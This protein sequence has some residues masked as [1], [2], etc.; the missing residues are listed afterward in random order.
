MIARADLDTLLSDRESINAE[1]RAVIDGPRL[2]VH[3]IRFPGG[4]LSIDVGAGGV[5]VLERPEGMR[6]EHTAR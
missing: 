5:D 6:I 2:A 4:Q 3:G 1:L